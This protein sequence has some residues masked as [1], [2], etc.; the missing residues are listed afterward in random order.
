MESLRS[1]SPQLGAELQTVVSF[2]SVPDGGFSVLLCVVCFGLVSSY[3]KHS[4]FSV[5]FSRPGS[6]LSPV[7]TDL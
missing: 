2:A 7:F 4:M 5:R 6:F 3:L 1:T